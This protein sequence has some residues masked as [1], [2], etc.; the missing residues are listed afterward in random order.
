ME[1][2]KKHYAYISREFVKS[3]VLVPNLTNFRVRVRDVSN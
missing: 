3:V 2:W 1:L